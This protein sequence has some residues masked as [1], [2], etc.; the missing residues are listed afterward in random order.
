MV[1]AARPV[2][3]VCQRE[4]AAHVDHRVSLADGGTHDVVNLQSLCHSCHSKKTVAQDGGFGRQRR[5][6]R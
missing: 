4:S 5:E 6:Y 1:L 3:E 2:C